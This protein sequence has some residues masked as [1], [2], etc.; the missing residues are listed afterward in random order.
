MMIMTLMIKRNN[1]GNIFICALN[2]VIYR[3]VS[4]MLI[5]Q[6]AYNIQFVFVFM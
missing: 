3:V 4:E 6:G 5:K 1:I 2:A